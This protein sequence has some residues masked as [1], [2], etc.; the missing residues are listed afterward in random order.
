MS[1]AEDASNL[2]SGAESSDLSQLSGSDFLVQVTKRA[3]EDEA[4]SY[5]KWLANDRHKDDPL[6]GFI[7]ENLNRI[8][9]NAKVQS[10][11]AKV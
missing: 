11:F 8:T 6:R 1:S 4:D 5:R 9:K 7:A 3:D 10:D 2:A